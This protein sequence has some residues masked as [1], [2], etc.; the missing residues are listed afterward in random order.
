MPLSEHL[1]GSVPDREVA[2]GEEPSIKVKRLAAGLV[3]VVVAL[4]FETSALA[5]ATVS[6]GESCTV[7]GATSVSSTSGRALVCTTLLDNGGG[8]DGLRWH[9][10]TAANMP[11]A[12]ETTTTEAPATTPPTVAE[13]PTTTVPAAAASEATAM[14][15]TGIDTGRWAG[16]AASLSA[17]GALLLIAARRR[18]RG[19]GPA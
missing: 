8:T 5:Q 19:F 11:G 3:T 14:P 7:T 17:L 1:L 2:R 4:A 16:E 9:I 6:E 12:E 10:Q 15:T 13:A 18:R